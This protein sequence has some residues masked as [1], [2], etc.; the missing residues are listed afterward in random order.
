MSL[1]KE[2]RKPSPLWRHASEALAPT[3]TVKQYITEMRERGATW[4]EV[5]QAIQHDAQLT[6]TPTLH[7]LQ[8]WAQCDPVFFENANA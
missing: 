2:G 3:Y 7:T 4:V 5:G 8:F 1:V 6:R